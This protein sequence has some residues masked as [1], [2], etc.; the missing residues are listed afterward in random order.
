MLSAVCVPLG[1]T[2]SNPVNQTQS[3]HSSV[4]VEAFVTFQHAF[5][6]AGSQ[7]QSHFIALHH[8]LGTWPGGEGTA[9]KG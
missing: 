2:T 8:L 6:S 4:Y 9:G 3:S 1:K 7:A 5:P